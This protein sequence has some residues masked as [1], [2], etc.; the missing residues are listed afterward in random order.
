MNSSTLRTH[1]YYERVTFFWDENNRQI[2]QELGIKKHNNDL[3]RLC[4]E[5]YLD[6]HIII[7]WRA[8]N[9]RRGGT[10]HENP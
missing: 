10:E 3:S 6:H 7:M 2:F 5:H 9:Y 1:N 4:S 8:G